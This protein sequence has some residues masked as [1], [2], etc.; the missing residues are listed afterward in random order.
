MHGRGSS[1][2]ERLCPDVFWGKSKSGRNH[3]FAFRPEDGDDDGSADRAETLRG[4]VVADCGGQITAMISL[5]EEDVDACSNW[6][7]GRA[8][9][10]KVRDVLNLDG[11]FLFFQGEDDMC[12]VLELLDWGIRGGGGCP[13]QRIR[14]P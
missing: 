2:A 14:S 6:S 13:R 1:R 5:V 11:I 7:G 12:D 9:Q 3:S 8:L 10:S 4:R